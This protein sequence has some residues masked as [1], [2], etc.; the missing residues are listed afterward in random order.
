M[1]TK[2]GS[3][4]PHRWI[5]NALIFSLACSN[6]VPGSA[7]CK[8]N[9]SESLQTESTQLKGI[10]ISRSRPRDCRLLWF[11]FISKDPQEIP[12]GMKSFKTQVAEAFGIR[13]GDVQTPL[14]GNGD[15]TGE[16]PSFRADG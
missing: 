12:H 6:L 10:E 13:A 15:Q 1:N 8:E 9:T 14:L 16:N 5:V 4:R 7:G 2:Q 3:A 11:T